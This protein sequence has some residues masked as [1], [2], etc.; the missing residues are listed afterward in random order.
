[1]HDITRRQAVGLGAT[2]SAALLAGLVIREAKSADPP[3]A[4]PV[5]T[6]TLKDASLDDVDETTGTITASFGKQPK[7]TQLV[8]L[9]VDKSVRVVASHIFPSIGNNRPFTWQQVRDLKGKKVSLRLTADGS[10][11]SV[12]SISAGN[13]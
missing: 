10:G 9:P 3:T 12:T 1:M 6:F 2:C 11:M 13:D 8:N 5:V 7:R 4:S